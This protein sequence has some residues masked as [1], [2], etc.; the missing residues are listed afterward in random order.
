MTHLSKNETD[1]S[2]LLR[3]RLESIG[4]EMN[5]F[6]VDVE[7]FSIDVDVGLN[8]LVNNMGLLQKNLNRV[9]GDRTPTIR[10]SRKVDAES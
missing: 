3:H 1:I 5:E 2:R 7:K 4:T 10:S 6:G 9:Q 8:N